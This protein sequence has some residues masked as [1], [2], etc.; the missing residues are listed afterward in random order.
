MRGIYYRTLG[1]WYQL[2]MQAA[3]YIPKALYHLKHDAF[4]WNQDSEGDITFRLFW[5]FHFTKY[6]E[7]T[8]IKVGRIHM[9]PAHKYYK[10]DI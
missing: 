7:H 10:A 2:R 4:K 5:V 6:K 8:I 3:Y 1:K 9:E